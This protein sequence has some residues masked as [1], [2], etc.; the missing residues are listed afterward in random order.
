MEIRV[1]NDMMTSECKKPETLGLLG[2]C[3][4]I[5]DIFCVTFVHP[6]L[7]EFWKVQPNQ[8]KYIE[9]CH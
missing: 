2:I 6:L 7:V 5:I 8:L 3:V 9:C 4:K 1:S